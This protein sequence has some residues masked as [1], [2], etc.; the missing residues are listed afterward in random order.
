MANIYGSLGGK[1]K[2]IFACVEGGNL[3]FGA[4]DYFPISGGAGVATTELRTQFKV[5]YA[6]I[7]TLMTVNIDTDDTDTDNTLQDRVA[8]VDGSQTLTITGTGFFQDTSNST[9]YALNDVIN[10][11]NNSEATSGNN[12]LR[13]ASAL[14]SES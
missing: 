5:P 4:V 3:G 7:L 10:G 14:Y 1:T 9:V 2:M 6:G 11:I 12:G 13:S 8:G